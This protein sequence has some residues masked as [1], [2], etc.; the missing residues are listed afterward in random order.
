[1]LKIC[2]QVSLVTT[3]NLVI[4]AIAILTLYVKGRKKTFDKIEKK[5]LSYKKNAWNK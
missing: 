4:I 1:M 3:E 2:F 5:S